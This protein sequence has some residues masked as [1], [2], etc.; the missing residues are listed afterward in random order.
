MT[1]SEQRWLE[2]G[3]FCVAALLLL[4]RCGCLRWLCSWA[5]VGRRMARAVQRVQFLLR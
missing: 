2:A 1:G 3:S 4:C 5:R